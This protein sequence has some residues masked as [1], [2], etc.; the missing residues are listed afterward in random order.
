[1][2]ER[3]SFQ[4]VFDQ[5]EAETRAEPTNRENAAIRFQT[6]RRLT[7]MLRLENGPEKVDSILPSDKHDRIVALLEGRQVEQA[8]ALIDTALLQ[9]CQLGRESAFATLRKVT[10]AGLDGVKL[11]GYLLAPDKP[12]Q[13]GFVWGHGG[14]GSKEGFIDLARALSQAGVH[15]LAIDFEGSGES[16]GYTR[17]IGRIRAFSHAIDYLET[18]LDLTEFGA[19]GHSGG[20]AYPAACAAIED[21]RISLLLLWDC[22]FDFYDTHIIEGAPDPGG[23]PACVLEHIYRRAQG[24]NTSEYTLPPEVVSFR[25]MDEHLDEIYEETEKT[26]RHYRYPSKIL[27]E[28]QKERQLAVLHVIAEDMIRP[29]QS[30]A[31]QD[32]TGG[33]LSV[34]SPSP[35]R[36]RFLHRPLRFLGS[37]LFNRPEGMWQRWHDELGEPKK[38]VIIPNITHGFEHPGRFEAIRE[39]LLAVDSWLQR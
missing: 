4:T 38:T 8:A 29:V 20:G 13:H 1:M 3:T 21:E 12:S 10:I 39:S 31:L 5:I 15:V 18:E 2:S 26:I 6:L 32:Y 25:R 14:F 24:Q 28:I 23:N 7:T 27:G 11:V 22:I 16:G 30:A 36:A 17:W 19:G 37:G 34:W 33:Q 35:V 9:L